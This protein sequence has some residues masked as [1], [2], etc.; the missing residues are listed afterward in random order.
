MRARGHIILAAISF[1]RRTDGDAGALLTIWC[2][3]NGVPKAQQSDVVQ[4][5]C[6]VIRLESVS[7]R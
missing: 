6:D 1:D 7:N 4:A 3:L 2:D 5:D